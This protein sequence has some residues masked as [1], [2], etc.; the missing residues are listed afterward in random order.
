MHFITPFLLSSLV[1]FASS[2]PVAVETLGK[3]A[4][5]ISVTEGKGWYV[6]ANGSPFLTLSNG[7]TFYLQVSQKLRTMFNWI[8]SNLAD[9]SH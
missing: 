3:R 1:A 9:I 2:N 6:Y 7:Q 8:S 4:N 5:T